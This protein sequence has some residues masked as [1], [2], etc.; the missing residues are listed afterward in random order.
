[1]LTLITVAKT[2]V[3][4]WLDKRFLEW[5]LEQGSSQTVVAFA[6]H[7]GVSRDVLNAWLNR[8]VT[9][10]GSNVD[11]LASK[12]GMEIYDILGLERPD[13]LLL[14]LE[15]LAEGLSEEG[16]AKLLK[17]GEELQARDHKGKNDEPLNGEA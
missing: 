9:P 15:K 7:L 6:E 4:Q 12:L 14:R 5:Q 10:R 2:K 13:P 3:A 16:R 1:M 11:L 17:I 8:G